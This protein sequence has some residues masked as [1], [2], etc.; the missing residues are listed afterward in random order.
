MF[1]VLVLTLFMAGELSMTSFFWH[2]II[3]VTHYQSSDMSF[4]FTLLNLCASVS[5]V[6][7]ILFLTKTL[8]DLHLYVELNMKRMQKV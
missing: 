7:V 2:L 6:D 3:M 5:Y 4:V 1:R 8:E